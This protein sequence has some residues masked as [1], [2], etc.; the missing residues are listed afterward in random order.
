MKCKYCGTE[1][2]DNFVAFKI[3]HEDNMLQ[4]SFICRYCNN[5]QT[6]KLKAEDVILYNNNTILPLKTQ[7]A[8]G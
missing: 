4:T 3:Q 5:P 7:L 2:I 6:I 8:K 1:D